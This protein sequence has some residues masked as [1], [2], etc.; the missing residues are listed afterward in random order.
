MRNPRNSHSA[1]PL[2]PNS[3]DMA[4]LEPAERIRHRSSLDTFVIPGRTRVPSS[5]IGLPEPMD[6]QIAQGLLNSDSAKVSEKKSHRVEKYGWLAPKGRKSPVSKGKARSN[7]ETS[8]PTSLKKYT[9]RPKKAPLT[10]IGRELLVVPQQKQHTQHHDEVPQHR[11]HLLQAYEDRPRDS[12]DGAQ[13]DGS[14]ATSTS[15]ST[16]SHRIISIS[17]NNAQNRA[18][19]K[20]VEQYNVLALKHGLSPLALNPEITQTGTTFFVLTIQPC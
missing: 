14:R 12:F 4:Y 13:S 6:I 17:S 15:W 20:S 19:L 1:A 5:R 8:I 16:I 11:E 9:Y 18:S 10:F 3:A 7:E 2:L